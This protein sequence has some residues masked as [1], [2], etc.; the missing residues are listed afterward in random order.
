MIPED[1]ITVN[2]FCKNNTSMLQHE[3]EQ[4]V[5]NYMRTYSDVMIK[6]AMYGQYDMNPFVDYAQARKRAGDDFDKQFSEI[7]QWVD[8]QMGNKEDV[9]YIEKLQK[10]PQ[11]IRWGNPEFIKFFISYEYIK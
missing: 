1:I 9:D 8:I 5:D 11:F 4:Y 3:R 6:S 10:N 2:Y 7:E